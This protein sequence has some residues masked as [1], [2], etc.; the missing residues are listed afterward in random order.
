MQQP[1]VTIYYL[2][3]VLVN[4]MQRQVTGMSLLVSGK[5]GLESESSAQALQQPDL[6]LISLLALTSRVLDDY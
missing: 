3:M 4:S 6:L 2:D 1:Y 5:I